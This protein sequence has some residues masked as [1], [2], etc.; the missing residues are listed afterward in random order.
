MVSSFP[1]LS[2]QIAA[3][4][5]HHWWLFLLRGIAAI[6]FAVLTLWWPGTTLIA[7]MAFIA[8]YALVDGIIAIAAAFQMRQL[9]ARWWV[10]LLQGLISAT[11]G[12]W[13][14]FQPALSLWYIVISVSVWM[15]VASMAQFALA[16]AHRAMGGTPLWAILGGI[17][18]LVLAVVALV[19]PN[20]TV[21]AVLGFIAW[22]ALVL[23]VLSLVVAFSVRS[24]GSRI[25]P[26]PA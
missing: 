17:V 25:G 14:F 23:G 8:A 7:L 26:A 11:F 10:V 22:F 4:V 21:A 3:S 19:Y 5:R 12:I 18:C 15:L 1:P 6:A 13:A 9:F 16:G 20:L 2:S 24:I